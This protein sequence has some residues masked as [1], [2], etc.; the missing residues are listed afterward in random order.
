M[1]VIAYHL[2]WT[3]YG[4]WLSN[5]PRGSGSREVY[6][7]V[8]AELG[9]AHFG[10]K[11]V[12]PSRT[13]V[14]RFYQQAEPRLQFPVIRFDAKQRNETGHSFADT[15]RRHQYMCY[16]CAILPDHAHLVVRKH[17]QDAETMIANLQSESR[18]RIIELGIAD[19]DHPVWTKN[20]WRVFLNTPEQVWQRIRYVENNPLKERSL[21]QEWPFVAPYDNWP[22]H[23][24][25]NRK[26]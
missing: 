8:L 24:Q 4:T 10:R 7:P 5:D 9:E 20:G 1:P 23:K 19:K 26:R 6:T 22:F 3:N 18:S 14:R 12:Q 25:L 2:I 17:K 15:I 13:N 21:R 16:A 11:P